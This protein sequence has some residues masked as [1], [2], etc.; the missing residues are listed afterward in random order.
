MI[1][2]NARWSTTKRPHQPPHLRRREPRPRSAGGQQHAVRDI[3]RDGSVAP[4]PDIRRPRCNPQ[5]HPAQS[6][7]VNLGSKRGLGARDVSDLA[8]SPAGPAPPDFN[9]DEPEA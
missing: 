3:T 4:F 5:I 7:V 9:L 2:D 6:L 1:R 8:S